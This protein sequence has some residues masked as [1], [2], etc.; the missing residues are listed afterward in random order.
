MALTGR[1]AVAAVVGMLMLPALLTACSAAGSGDDVRS[2]ASSSAGAGVGAGVGDSTAAER[3]RTGAAV[4]A[5]MRGKGYDEE[6][7]SGGSSRNA[8]PEGVDPQQYQQDQAECIR[9]HGLAGE[10]ASAEE[11]P[12][13]LFRGIANCMRAA[14]FS[15]YPDD[16]AGQASYEPAGDRDTFEDAV[17]TCESTVLGG[18]GALVQR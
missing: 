8:I 3:N 10:A 2:V 9:E 15:D 11:A 4:A 13:E 5:C 18:R 17:S 12:D 7:P 1:T 14:G 6:D 16:S